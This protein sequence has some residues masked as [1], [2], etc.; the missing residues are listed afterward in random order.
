MRIWEHLLLSLAGLIAVVFFLYQFSF[1]KY[2]IFAVLFFI[3]FILL[4]LLVPSKKSIHQS[5]FRS[6]RLLRILFY[7]LIALFII[8]V[9]LFTQALYVLF[10]VLGYVAHLL[11]DSLTPRGLATN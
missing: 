6:V 11:A 5:F 7:I 8:A 4:D 10:V 2:I 3:G 1:A 9:F